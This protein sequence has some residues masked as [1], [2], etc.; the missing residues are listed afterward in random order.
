MGTS[1]FLNGTSPSGTTETTVSS[2]F[3]IKI[4]FRASFSYSFRISI[5]FAFER[6][7]PTSSRIS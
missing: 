3:Q 2:K 4:V 6:C 5:F 7:L 1:F